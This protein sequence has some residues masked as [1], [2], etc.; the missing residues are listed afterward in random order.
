[1]GT[2]KASVGAYVL[3]GV[4]DHNNGY[5][6]RT[7]RYEKVPRQF[8]KEIQ[9]LYSWMVRLS[10]PEIRWVSQ[11]YILTLR[12]CV[13]SAFRIMLRDFRG[14]RRGLGACRI[15]R[16]WSM[17]FELDG[18]SREAVKVQ[19]RE[20]TR[21]WIVHQVIYQTSACMNSILMVVLYLMSHGQQ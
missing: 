19:G 8:V 15:I 14:R 18:R 10:Y 1:M 7:F 2:T 3:A 6:T 16:S 20:T 13:L 17:S 9:K 5:I 21:L 4:I 12:F 11:S